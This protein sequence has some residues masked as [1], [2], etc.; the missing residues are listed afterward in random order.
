MT[1]QDD[2]LKKLVKVLADCSVPYMVSG[3]FG[4][5]FVMRWELPLFSGIASMQIICVSGPK[6]YRLRSHLKGFS[7]RREN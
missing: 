6:S 2:F 1:S 7:N 5:S 4:G 3:S